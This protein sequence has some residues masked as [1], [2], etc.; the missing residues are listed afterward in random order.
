MKNFVGF[1]RVSSRE[2]QREG[3]SLECQEDAIREHAQRH[4]GTVAKMFRVTESAKSSEARARFHEALTYVRANRDCVAGIIFFSVDRATRNM[5]DFLQIVQ[6]A[7]EAGIEVLFVE[8]DLDITNPTGELTA[9]VQTML[10][11][12]VIRQQAEKASA[13]RTRRV[14]EGLF[15][16]K[17][18]FA[19]K[20]YQD[21]SGRRLI[22][23]DD[24]GASV[25]RR[26]YDLYASG[27]FTLDSLREQLAKEGVTQTTSSQPITRSKLHKILCDRS[28]IGEILYRGD[29][30]PGK[31][32]PLVDRATF[33]RVQRL[34]GE[35]RYHSHDS[36]FAGLLECGEC[37]R[38]ITAEVKRPRNT[39]YTYYRCSRYNAADHDRTRIREEHLDAQFVQKLRQLQLHDDELRDWF[40]TALRER[41]AATRKAAEKRRSEMRQAL[42]K[43]ETK[44][45]RVLELHLEYAIDRS[46]FL[47]QQSSLRDQAEQL[48]ANLAAEERDQSERVDTA[49]KAFELVENL[50]DRWLT[51]DPATKRLILDLVSL[52]RTL[53]AGSLDITWTSPFHLLA[54]QAEEEDGRSERI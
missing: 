37:G 17:A 24:N 45:E 21:D 49:A 28:Y 15:P 41:T 39:V 48:R 52:K 32:T 23:V 30:H 47:D 1:A 13:A 6:L 42:M 29:W 26:I 12:F 51:A 27:S 8:G 34:L 53:T 3:F 11:R 36:T 14:E 22:R 50:A 44:I 5:E 10:G 38:K 20:N 43:T 33:S 4:T 31:H 7:G 54:E 40:A 9:G 16:C 19:Y 35:G 18:P 46:T 2:Q 25:V